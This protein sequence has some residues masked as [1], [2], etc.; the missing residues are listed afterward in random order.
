MKIKFDI[1]IQKEREQIILQ[2]FSLFAKTLMLGEDVTIT[3]LEINDE[4][5]IDSGIC[6][7]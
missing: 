4:S 2:Y 6:I 1:P 5:V 7:Y 3:D